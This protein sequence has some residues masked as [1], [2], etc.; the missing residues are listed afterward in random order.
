MEAKILWAF[1]CFQCSLQFYKKSTY[2]FH[3][4]I[5]HYN[6]P[7]VNSSYTTAV[8]K[9]YQEIESS[10]DSIS[11]MKEENQRK[12]NLIS[13]RRKTYSCSICVRKFKNSGH[14]KEHVKRHTGEKPFACIHCDKRFIRNFDLKIHI[15]THTG[16][17]P[18]ACKKCDKRFK[19]SNP[20]KCHEKNS[21]R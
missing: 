15:R 9:E 12:E 19:L 1:Y 13:T 7:I 3:Q 2:N 21:Y 17:K 16:E 8:K 5:V 6:K 20:L 11:N 10:N 4:S 14:L 18:F